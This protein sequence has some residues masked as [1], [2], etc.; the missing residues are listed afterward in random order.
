[1]RLGLES[2]SE[3][4]VVPG[5]GRDPE[6]LG[7]VEQLP[8][9]AGRQPHHGGLGRGLDCRGVGSAP[10]LDHGRQRGRHVPARVGQ[11]RVRHG[12]GGPV[13]PNHG[14]EALVPLELDGDPLRVLLEESHHGLVDDP[15]EPALELHREAMVGAD[16][17]EVHGDPGAPAALAGGAPEGR[18]EPQVVEDHGPDVEDEGL[19]GI[20]GLLDHR[21]ELPDLPTRR[22]GIALEQPLR[23]LGLEHD[24]GQALGRPVVHLAGDLA[25]QVLLGGE[26]DPRDGRGNGG[27]IVV[28]RCRGG[29][30]RSVRVA[31]GLLER[32]RV[33]LDG[34]AQAVDGLALALEDLELGLHERHAAGQGGDLVGLLQDLAAA[35]GGRGLG[36]LVRG[37]CAAR[38]VA[39]GLRAG[40]GHEQVDLGDLPLELRRLGAEGRGHRRRID[41]REGAWSVPINPRA[42]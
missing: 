1:M 18:H 38:L 2:Q 4:A 5:R 33:G 23:D 31:R 11:V 7:A 22:G 10:V 40:L 30:G 36:E 13:G 21:H 14:L 26:D 41:H 15:E 29:G 39:C 9:Q 37:G 19:R 3:G 34:L 12:G 25:A 16:A 24:V 32:G 42:S 20:E 8:R 17:L 6:R 28:V 27:S 35:R